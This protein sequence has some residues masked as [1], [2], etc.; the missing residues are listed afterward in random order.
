[1]MTGGFSEDYHYVSVPHRYGSRYS[2]IHSTELH[3]RNRLTR[4]II[5]VGIEIACFQSFPDFPEAGGELANKYAPWPQR[6]NRFSF[7]AVSML[8]R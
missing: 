7:L 4:V 2:L 5:R 3:G 1:M 6:R 8:K